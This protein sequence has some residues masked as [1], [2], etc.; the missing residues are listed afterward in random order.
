MSSA[1]EIKFDEEYYEQHRI[2]QQWVAALNR[3][4]RVEADRLH[5]KLKMSAEGLMAGK[6]LFGADYIRQEGYN[7]ENADKKYGSD[8]LDKDDGPPILTRFAEE[9]RAENDNK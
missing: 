8:W 7:T 3:G 5:R 6:K 9:W 4:N 1:T 2:R